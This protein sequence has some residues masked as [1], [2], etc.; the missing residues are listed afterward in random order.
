LYVH[1]LLVR[2]MQIIF[3][4]VD[5]LPKTSLILLTLFT[6]VLWTGLFPSDTLPQENPT[7]WEVCFS[8][9][10][11]CLEAITRE[12]G[13]AKKSVLVQAYSFTSV[14]IAEALVDAHK[15]G[16]KV[17]V[18]LDKSRRNEKKSSVRFLSERG[19]QV[20]ID[21][22][23]GIA[24]NKVMIIDGEAVITGSFN[25][26]KN[27]EKKNAENLLIIHDRKLAEKY[28]ENWLEHAQYSNL[29][30]GNGATKEDPVL[31]EVVQETDKVSDPER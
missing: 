14:P 29:Y 28:I 16:V 2:E 21:I 19:V 9:G 4:M 20:R 17:E 11:N 15:R 26:T 23:R 22:T 12:L 31:R 18:I 13:K 5:R 7:T 24:H 30:I 25:F 3:Y 27:A 8:P 1:C 10:E 6:L